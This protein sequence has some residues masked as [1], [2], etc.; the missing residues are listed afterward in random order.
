MEALEP[1]IVSYLLFKLGCAHPYYVSRALLLA[2]WVS[3][4]KTGKKL[5]KLTYQCQPYG[6][7]IEELSPIIDDLEKQ[8]CAR[9]NQ[10]KKCVEYS[11]GEP[12]LPEW[13]KEVLDEVVEKTRGLDRSQLNKLV[14]NDPRY[15]RM[16]GVK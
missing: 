2:E 15:K 7:Y 1:R 3:E 16:L 6:F 12:E 8:G 5:T 11:C 13:I 9:R 4:E 10:E 14:I